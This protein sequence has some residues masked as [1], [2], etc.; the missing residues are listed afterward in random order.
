[1]ETRKVQK[2]GASTLTV[3]LPKEWVQRRGVK[4]GDQ[5]FLQEEGATIRV[6]P[7]PAYAQPVKAEYLVSADLCDKPGML[8]RALVGN[9]V[10]GRDRL[11]VKGTGRLSTEHLAEIR[12]S[13]RRLMGMGIIEETPAQVALQCS[14]DPTRYPI[15]A[16][17]KRMYNISQT[18]LDLSV[19]ALMTRD[20]SLARDAIA[21]EDD[22]DTLYYLVLRLVLS[23]QMDEGLLEPLGI[24]SRLEIAGNR[25]VA[26]DLEG[27]ADLCEDIAK[28]VLVILDN[29]L[30]VPE[31][32]A[33]GFRARVEKVKKA[34]TA[35]IASLL[36]HDFRA[37]YEAGELAREF[38][39]E[40]QSLARQL[41]REGRSLEMHLAMRS[42]LSG[43]SRLGEYAKSIS[44]I[45]VNR[46][47]ER[48]TNL[49]KPVTEP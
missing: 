2:V 31:G 28:N 4:Q 35:A 38:Q 7:A 27:V 20:A 8:T 5:V 18:M 42:I 37:A 15:D 44:M 30:R 6:V 22:A 36:S 9:Y 41:L 19:E 47:L 49:C 32:V 13:S 26:R 45:A 46:Y 29:D 33:K 43:L 10:L 16:L 24:K 3:S 11:R 48:P 40:V 25:A 12:D 1:M 17:L 39:G 23:A 34:Y 14:I 21:R